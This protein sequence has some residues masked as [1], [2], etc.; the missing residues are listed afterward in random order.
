MS[1]LQASYDGNLPLLKSL[2][3]NGENINIQDEDGNNALI[4]ACR[5]TVNIDTVMWLIQQGLS[6]EY[7]NNKGFNA[8]LVAA[9]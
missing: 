7:K 8:F 2:K 4:K 1:V 9:C 3:D 5:G 6:P